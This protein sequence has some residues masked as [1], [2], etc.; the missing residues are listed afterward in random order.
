[1]A[2]RQKGFRCYLRFGLRSLLFLPVLV[3]IVYAWIGRDYLRVRRERA[4]VKVIEESNGMVS[5][6]YQVVNDYDLN[7]DLGPEG[8]RFERYLFGDDIRSSVAGVTFD[9]DANCDEALELLSRL[10]GLRRLAYRG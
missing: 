9:V 3:G 7:R 4:I 8:S 5:Y 10:Q 1:M 2:V 6:D